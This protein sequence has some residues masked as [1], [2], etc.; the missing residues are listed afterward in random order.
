MLGAN[1]IPLAGVRIVDGSG[2]SVLD[3]VT[4]KALSAILVNIW[5]DPS[6]RAV[7]TSALAVSGRR[8]TLVNRLGGVRM[9][10]NVV[11]KTGTTSLSSALSGFVRGRYA[12][13]VIQNGNPV[14]T[15]SARAAQD[16]FVEALAAH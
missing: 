2:L 7:L 3:R 11:A 5:S 13:S 6:L 16:R 14:P 12:F 4:P 1:H 10:G 9:R 8:G 15:W